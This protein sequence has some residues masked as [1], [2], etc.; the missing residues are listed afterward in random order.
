MDNNENELESSKIDFNSEFMWMVVL[1]SIFG[2]GK[3]DKK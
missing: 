1:L 2:G 3:D